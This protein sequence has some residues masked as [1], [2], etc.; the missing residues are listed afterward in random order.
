MRSQGGEYGAGSEKISTREQHER[1]SGLYRRSGPEFP[2]K[3][4]CTMAKSAKEKDG[5]SSLELSLRALEMGDVLTSRRLAR[6]VIAAPTP[7]DQSVASKVALQLTGDPSELSAELVAQQI[8]QRGRP[9]LRPYLWAL[10]GFAAFFS[11]WIMS[12]VR[13]R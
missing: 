9:I 6:S 12:V 13:Y 3:E 11:L 8:V 4:S 1:F 10:G 7:A 2:I 5:K